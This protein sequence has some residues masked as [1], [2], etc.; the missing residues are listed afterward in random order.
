MKCLKHKF[1]EKEVVAG[2]N[3][4]EISSRRELSKEEYPRKLSTKIRII[5]SISNINLTIAWLPVGKIL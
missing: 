3:H 2:S 1:S 4:N 5:G